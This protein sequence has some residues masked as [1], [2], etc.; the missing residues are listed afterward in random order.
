MFRR[1]L[2]YGRLEDGLKLSE[3]VELNLAAVKRQVVFED[4]VHGGAARKLGVRAAREQ[5]GSEASRCADSCANASAFGGACG[6]GAYAIS[7]SSCGYDRPRFLA[8]I[9]A[10]GDFAFRIHG[11]LAAR[12][13]AARSGPQVNRIAVWQDQRI[14]AHAKFATAFNAAG[15]LGFQQFAA[16]IGTDR[17]DDA[18]V[19]GNRKGRLKIDGVTGFGTARGDTVLEDNTHS[20]SRGNRDF[21][22]GACGLCRSR[23]R[24]DRRRRVGLWAFGLLSGA[25]RAY[26]QHACDQKQGFTKLLAQQLSHGNPPRCLMRCTKQRSR[27]PEYNPTRSFSRG[28]TGE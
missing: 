18:I 1:L 10:A 23:L 15:A 14:E 21:F 3:I 5:N 2:S 27:M 22:T 17:D 7:C 24:G 8:F 11:F 25:R 6:D 12:V 28:L 4:H 26:C 20:R 13:R 16:K 9:A 19:L